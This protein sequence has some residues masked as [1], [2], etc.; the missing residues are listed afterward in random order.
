[1][2]WRAAA[3]ASSGARVQAGRRADLKPDEPW[4]PAVKS[5]PRGFVRIRHFGLLANRQRRTLIARARALLPVPVA[6]D[7]S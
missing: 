7:T 1:M 4:R 3:C 2:G 5:P 6:P